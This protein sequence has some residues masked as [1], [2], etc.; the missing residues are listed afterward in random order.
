MMQNIDT[1]DINT[2]TGSIYDVI[3]R[4]DPVSNVGI[5]SIG[6]AGQACFTYQ[7]LV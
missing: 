4:K 1:N 7:V 3:I 2:I 6:L 5:E